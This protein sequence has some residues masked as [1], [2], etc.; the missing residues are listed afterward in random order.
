M[1]NKTV[2]VIAGPTAI[3]KTNIGIQ[4][5]KHFNTEIISADSRQCYQELNIGVARPSQEELNAVPHHF[6]ASHS[7]QSPVDAAGYA[8]L[9]KFHLG[10]IF[11][12]N[13]F[14]VIVGGTG[15]YLKALL[16]GIDDIP[17]INENVKKAIAQNVL[18]NG[19]EWLVAELQ[20]HDPLYLTENPTINNYRYQRALGIVLSHQKSI[21]SY[22]NKT[23]QAL[24]YNVIG[25][26]LYMQRNELYSRINNRVDIMLQEGLMKEVDS[27]L[28]FKDN[29]LM[30]TIGYKEAIEHLEGLYTAKEMEEKIKQH[31]RNYAK[32]QIT[33]FTHQTTFTPII[34]NA[35]AILQNMETHQI[36]K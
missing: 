26:Q 34:V 22:Q 19:L 6:I 31:T 29:K 36:I 1:Q 15:L 18:T 14:A 3:G 4:I 17:P 13:D 10:K 7:L 27:L 16:E 25:Y 8:Y 11:S 24:P 28:P 21:L 20:D 12:Q 33:W 30:H 23:K 9:A 35:N 32:R 2:I 5:A